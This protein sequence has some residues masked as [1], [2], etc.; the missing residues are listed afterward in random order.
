[1]KWLKIKSQMT[2]FFFYIM[3]LLHLKKKI[4]LLYSM[5][6]TKI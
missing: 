4:L 2:K 3:L 5:A 6:Y 1:M